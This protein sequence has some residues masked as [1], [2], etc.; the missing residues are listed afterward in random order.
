MQLGC[1]FD[2][3]QEIQLAIGHNIFH[4]SL[5]QRLSIYISVMRMIKEGTGLE[6][7]RNVLALL[8]HYLDMG[9]SSVHIG[10]F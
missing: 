4:I 1:F 5:E 3:S 2:F 6:N 9:G 10:S 7:Q 8:Q